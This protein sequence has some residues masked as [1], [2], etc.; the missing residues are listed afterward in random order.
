M[1]NVT[2]MTIL[3]LAML[4]GL[5][6]AHPFVLVQEGDLTETGGGSDYFN[7]EG[8]HIV[9]RYEAETTDTYTSTWSG[10]GM[11]SSD[12]YDVIE[13]TVS[14][15][16]RPGGAS[17]LLNAN[18][19]SYSQVANVFPPGIPNDWI[20]VG[21]GSFYLPE[22][23]DLNI[24]GLYFDLGSQNYFPGTGAVGDLSFLDSV[25]WSSAVPSGIEVDPATMMTFYSITNFSLAVNP[26]LFLLA[27]NGGESIMNRDFNITWIAS[28]DQNIDRVKLEYSTDNSLTW[29]TIDPNTANDGEHIWNV[30]VV[31][32][33]ECVVRVSDVDDSAA[34]DTSDELFT[35]FECHVP[36]VTGD[37]YIDLND[38]AL[39]SQYWLSCGNIF[40]PACVFE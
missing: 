28:P 17:D 19:P 38:F 5:A 23:D 2:I 12:F 33:E 7:L 27:P 10:S 37:C 29:K 9:I 11:V 39:I 4:V 16:G 34:N 15:T 20:E 3:L 13:M 6:H 31:D 21:S 14:I 24:S 35:I 26:E 8:T 40:N 32:S 18:E 30:P 36:D 22:G 1:K 25:N